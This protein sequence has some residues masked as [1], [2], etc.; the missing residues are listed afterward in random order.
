M[1]SLEYQSSAP[2]E[3]P[4][5]LNLAQAISIV[6]GTVVGSAVFLVPYEMTR[7]A[8][9]FSLVNLAWILG[10]LLS[11]AGAMTYAELGAMR[12]FAGGE[13]VYLRDAYGDG[14][15]F[16]YMW[17]WFAIAKPASI[18][19]V[20]S[21]LALTLAQFQSFAFLDH[22]IPHTPILWAQVLAIAATWLITGLN[23][24][25]I[26]KAGDFQLA[27]TAFKVL[28][29]LAVIA[30]C[31]TLRPIVSAPA[32]SPASTHAHTVPAGNA[33]R[34]RRAKPSAAKPPSHT[35]PAPI[36]GVSPAAGGAGGFMVALIA[37]LWAY[38][39]WN[40]LSMVG[41]EVRSPRR[42][43]PM[44]LVGGTAAVILLYL[45]VSAA[46]E[47]LLP[48]AVIASSP[49]PAMV[50]LGLISRPWTQ[51]V[52]TV[53][54]AVGI[55]VGLN[56]TI[57]SGA[58]VPYAAAR[59]RLFFRML[60]QVH[61]RFQ[62]PAHSL[63]VQGLLSTALLLAIGRFQQLFELAIFSEW[64][65]Y[66]I[67]STTLFVFRRREPLRER[68]FRVPGYPVTPALFLAASVVLLW[69]SY[70]AN[71]RGSL[72]GTAIILCGVPLYRYFRTR[73]GMEAAS[74]RDAS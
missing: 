5:A 11:L 66:A 45:G 52:L 65:F 9:S 21:G 2:H 26:R 32:G 68:P 15:A 54:M 34:L 16:L 35:H 12:P 61:P 46:L 71:L 33:A 59:D 50:A 31:F 25:G 62:S 42:N 49:R 58:R 72:V 7:A 63:V 53:G 13:Y 30:M 73:R 43:L 41:G 27:F 51:T 57:M 3:L 1:T 17:T 23:C 18:A 24:L 48:L 56:G 60:A 44:A 67:T 4:R 40:D 10:G 74:A 55:L 22:A 28:L 69:Y 6:I 38:D 47:H 14:T 29:I 8:G 37:A 20:T 19:S 36:G 64:L 39:G 70:V